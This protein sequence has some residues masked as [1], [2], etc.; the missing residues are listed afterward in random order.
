MSKYIMRL[1]DAAA[2]MDIVKWNRM[3]KLLDEYKI[4]PLVGVIPDCKDPMMAQYQVNEQFWEKVH[5]WINK[6][7]TIALHGYEHVYCTNDGG[8]NPVNKSSEFAGVPLDEQ[9]T[10]IRKGLK[11]FKEHGIEPKV[12]FA[13]SHTFDE[14]TIEAIKQESNV[15]VISDTIANNAYC[16][17]GMVFVPQQLGAVRKLPFQVVTFCYHPNTMKDDDYKKLEDFL[18]QFGTKFVDFGNICSTTRKYTFIDWMLKKIYFARRHSCF[19]SIESMVNGKIRW[20]K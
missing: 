13:P 6:G 4:K 17:Y 14:N 2:K 16:K 8:I 15:R 20:R 12:F 19:A 5:T 9:K 7:W 18:Q 1:D 10:K 3:E 11:I